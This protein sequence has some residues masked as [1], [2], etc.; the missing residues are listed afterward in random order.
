MPLAAFGLAIVFGL[1]EAESVALLLMGMCP[2]G[3]TSTLFVY[4]CGA[5]VTVSLVMT[6]L[7]TFAALFMMPLLLFAYA[8][9]PLT[10]SGDSKVSYVAIVVTLV[11][12]TVPA[13]IGWRIR[14]KYAAFGEKLEHIATRLGFFLVVATIVAIFAWPVSGG[15]AG[16]TLKAIIVMFLLSPVG[17]ALGYF[18]A[19]FLVGLDASLARTVSIE[20]G[21]QQV[22]IAGAIAV[23]SFR[24]DQ[25]Q[26]M[27][28]MMAIFGLFTFLFG[29]L[30]A[31]ILRACGPPPDEKSAKFELPKVLGGG[32]KS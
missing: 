20:T 14:A 8:R 29:L 31:T 16:V 5:N 28:S 26:K 6:T 27:L 19:Y 1:G 10:N 3:V 23:N 11:I 24:G 25:L 15:A 22:G 4:V 30:W 32:T 7:S 12:A 21:I 9:P 2:G 13:L 17:F 18:T